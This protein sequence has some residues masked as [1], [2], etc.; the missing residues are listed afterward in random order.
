MLNL[1]KSR[2]AGKRLRTLLVLFLTVFFTYNFIAQELGSLKG[3]YEISIPQK[4][5]KLVL[6]PL[7]AGTYA[8]G[9][10][11]YFLTIDS[12]FNKLSIDGIAGEVT[13]ELIDD[14]YTAPADTF[15][16]LLD[17]PIPG[18]GPNS[19]VTIKPAANKN[20]TVEGNWR[21]VFT[22]RD[23]SYLTLDGVATEGTTTLTVHSIYNAQYVTNRGIG[24]LNNSDF[25]VIQNA[26]VICDDYLR[27]G[28]GILLQAVSNSLFAP[29]SNLIQNNFIKKAGCGI[30]VSAYFAN[31]DTR[32]IGNIIR[33]NKLGSETDSL[34]AWGI[35][36]EKSQSAIIENNIVQ[37]L[38]VNNGY[39]WDNVNKGINSYWGNGDIIRN[40][41]VHNIKG[42]AGNHATGVQLSGDAGKT[43]SSNMVYNNMVYNIQSTSTQSD[44][45]VAGIQ[46]WY[47]D[48]PKIYYNSVYLFGTGANHSGSAALYIHH[49][50]TNAEAKNNILVNTRDESPYYASA[51]YDYSASNLTSDYNDLY[52]NNC[53]VRIGSTNYTTLADWQVT[54]QDLHSYVEMP[55]FISSTDLHINETIPTYLESRGIPIIGID[56]DYDGDQ[57]N[58]DSTDIGAD[59]FDGVYK[60][61]GV[62]DEETL[63]TEFV[64]EQNYP[65]P[66]NPSTTI[67]WQLPEGSNVTLKIFSALGEE[68]ITLI[69]EYRPAGKYETEFN[70]ANLPSGV[71]FYRLKAGSFIETKKMILLK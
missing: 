24:F 55:P 67:N 35:Q 68:I 43:G 8:V 14:L 41:I 34:I 28:P 51:I 62:E 52:S 16:F 18:A 15:G 29:D 63:P 13:L 49:N 4:I 20:V 45:R 38:T 56:T 60:V 50:C 10:G 31:A 27:E 48:N 32:P 44:S 6:D 66:F 40:N 61:T 3:S 36:L 7:P 25:N 65:N 70:A 1:T 54:T 23:V 47:Q 5:H 22:F 37:N 71:Y 26:I 19:R 53:L 2:Y 69:N 46:T 12:A 11:G 42:S 64:L 59:E 17:G 39:V 58:A 21:Y 33:G 30:Y 9:A 57:R